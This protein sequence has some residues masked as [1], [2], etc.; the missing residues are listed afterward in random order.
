MSD[1]NYPSIKTTVVV[2][3]PGTDQVKLVK[4][5]NI[6]TCKGFR[7]AIGASEELQDMPED[8]LKTRVL[9]EAMTLI[10]RDK[11][12]PMAVH[13]AFLGLREYRLT[14]AE[15]MPGYEEDVEF[16]KGFEG[17]DSAYLVKRVG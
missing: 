6:N 2:W 9:A 12:D 4:A 15:D 11:C 14:C 5:K 16:P 13:R 17:V 10:V 7:M 8:K 3:N 1:K